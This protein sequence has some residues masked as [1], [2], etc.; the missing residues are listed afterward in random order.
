MID[1]KIT[2]RLEQS[3]VQ[4]EIIRQEKPIRS[5]ADAE[6]YYPLEKSAPTFVLQTENGLLGCFASFQNGRLDFEALKARF[7]FQK[8]KMAD[9]KKIKTLTGYDAGSIPL[10][11]LDIP[12]LFDQKL[13]RHDVVYGGTGDEFATLKISPADLL[14]LNE[15]AGRFE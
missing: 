9:R 4:Y 2:G 14:K 15:I 10:V 8:L 11:G 13:L 6:G 3:G 7:G 5:A 12:C 1:P